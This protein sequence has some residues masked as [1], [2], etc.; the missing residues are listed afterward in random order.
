M[1]DDT[2]IQLPA[3]DTVKK[4]FQLFARNPKDFLHAILPYMVI[5]LV[6]TIV[7]YISAAPNNEHSFAS[8]HI[9]GF[10][11]LTLFVL[12]SISAY[13][14]LYRLTL[15]AEK[16]EGFALSMGRR[17]LNFLGWNIGVFL[18]AVISFVVVYIL[19]LAVPVSAIV[20]IPAATIFWTIAAYRL[21]FIWPALALDQKANWRTSNTQ[22]KGNTWNLMWGSF[23]VL[24]PML[25]ISAVVS[26]YVLSTLSGDVM[27]GMVAQ[28]SSDTMQTYMT[29]TVMPMLNHAT[30]SI[31]LLLWPVQIVTFIVSTVFT[32]LSYFMLAPESRT[33]DAAQS[34]L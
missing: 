5:G 17:E 13:V 23:L 14:N 28:T 2:L 1:T 12:S 33:L 16:P 31:P 15:L 3:W 29:T 26:I 20:T 21:S 30:R 19:M 4:S 32:A 27:A 9:L 8:S 7:K 34:D 25:L 18:V 22:I 11:L 6:Y 10:A 24:M